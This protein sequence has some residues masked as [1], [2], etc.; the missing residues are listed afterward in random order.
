VC[1]HARV[2]VYT[3]VCIC[4]FVHVCVSQLFIFIIQTCVFVEGH[5][6]R[7]TLLCTYLCMLP[8]ENKELLL[9]IFVLLLLLILLLLLL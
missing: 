8:S 9:F 3:Y 2:C 4:V 1:M 5:V 7:C 6:F